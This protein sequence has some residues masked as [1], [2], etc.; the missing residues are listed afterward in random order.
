MP[1][2]WTGKIL[3]IDLSRGEVSVDATLPYTQAFIGGRGIAAK[4]LYDECGPEIRPF[5]PGNLLIFSTASLAGTPIPGGG[6]GCC[7]LQV[8][9]DRSRGAQVRDRIWRFLGA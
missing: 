9:G 4:I 2:G 6:K 1:F 3:R 8:S 7:H 5:D